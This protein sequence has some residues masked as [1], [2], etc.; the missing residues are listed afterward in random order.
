MKRSEH[1]TA[2]LTDG[3]LVRERDELVRRL[4]DGDTKII[5]ARTSGADVS[6]LETLWISLLHEYEATSD[7]I[8]RGGSSRLASA[9]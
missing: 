2:L 3:P 8:A 9:A 4:Q 7:A 1:P 6:R 5:L